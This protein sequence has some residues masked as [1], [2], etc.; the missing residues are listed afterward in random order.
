MTTSNS[1]LGM[2][3]SPSP[4]VSAHTFLVGGTHESMHNLIYGSFA[5][6]L[7]LAMQVFACTLARMR[8]T[9]KIME[10]FA[11]L[12]VI[13]LCTSTLFI[14]GVFLSR[15]VIV[16]SILSVWGARLV[17][18]HRKRPKSA[19]TFAS[20]A[21]PSPGDLCVTRAVWA[22]VVSAPAILVNTL[23]RRATGSV[24]PHGHWDGIGLVCA[25]GGFAL[26]WAADSQK[27]AWYATAPADRRTSCTQTGVWRWSRH[28]NYAGQLCM[29]LGIYV[30]VSQHTPWWSVIGL[31]FTLIAL[32]T[33]DGGMMTLERDKNIRLYS[34]TDFLAYRATTSPLVPMSPKLYIALHWR[35]KTYCL[36][37]WSAYAAY[38]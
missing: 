9:G 22:W 5:C 17:A 34:K 7:A 30:L 12:S 6:A 10:D 16:T 36:F 28:P 3:D 20:E 13:F 31:L 26:E 33:L 25:I 19:Y 32:T 35:V 8:G 23:D 29:H 37:E 38:R 1:S 4:P 2:G 18:M 24:F 27:S 14:R 11:G 21:S 15:Q